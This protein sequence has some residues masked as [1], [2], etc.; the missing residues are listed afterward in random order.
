[1]C[2]KSCGS[3]YGCTNCKLVDNAIQCSLRYSTSTGV[4]LC[5]DTPC[6]QYCGNAAQCMA[7]GCSVP[8]VNSCVQSVCTATTKDACVASPACMW[9]AYSLGAKCR[10]NY[11]ITYDTYGCG[12]RGNCSWDATAAGTIAN[13]SCQ[14]IDCPYGASGACNNNPRCVWNTTLVKCHLRPCMYSTAARCLA[15]STCEWPSWSSVCFYRLC[16]S[17]YDATTCNNINGCE[18]IGSSCR[19]WAC[20]Y[21]T[22]VACQADSQ[23][24]VDDTGKCKQDCRYRYTT[25]TACQT[26]SYT[27]DA[28][29]CQWDYQGSMCVR[30]C[31]TFLNSNSC[32]ASD[33]CEWGYNATTP[34]CVQRCSQKYQTSATCG[35]DNTCYWNRWA[36]PAICQRNCS[37]L[38][39]YNLSSCDVQPMCYVQEI[40]PFICNMRCSLRPNH[41][42]MTVCNNDPQ[43]EWAYDGQYCTSKICRWEKE[44]VCLNDDNCKWQ[45][46]TC[47]R[48]CGFLGFRICAFQTRCDWLNDQRVRGEV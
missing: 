7:K 47:Q 23:C 16:Q 3:Y 30:T 11:C 19:R 26:P 15:D 12:L 24:F 35:T 27:P 33:V 8:T 45:N 14:E 1:M 13:P 31:S 36:S 32:S 40:D 28:A 44:G 42:N 37:S 46:N 6:T 18:Y 34:S 4:G 25:Q 38:W 21:T 20:N 29:R 41:N 5:E 17:W 39:I 48:R 9:D 43:C 22:T 10:V 2:R